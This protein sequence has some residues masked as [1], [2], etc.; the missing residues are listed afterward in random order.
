MNDI[1]RG[2]RVGIGQASLLFSITLALF[3]FVGYR[4][5]A[6]EFYSGILITQFGLIMLPAVLFLLFFRY[7]IK[8]ILRLNKIKPINIL[9]IFVIM[10]FAIPLVA[11]FNLLNLFLVK[12]I[13]GDVIINQ[14]PIAKNGSEL[15][16]NLLVI[17]GSAGIC[18]EVLFRGVLQRGYERFGVLKAIL[19][20]SFLFSLTHADFQKIF[21]TFL[22]GALIGFFVYRTNSLLSG[23]FAHFTNNAL[24]VLLTYVSNKF[25][26]AF[27]D[28]GANASSQA[29]IN[30]VFSALAEI[31]KEQLIIVFFI[32]GILFLFIAAVFVLLLYAFCKINPVKKD[33]EASEPIRLQE[34]ASGA[35]GLIWLLPGITMIAAIYLIQASNMLGLEIAFV[36]AV[37][38]LLF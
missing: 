25:L 29:D 14:I 7:D 33:V 9:I 35:K 31:P 22:L 30:S 20:T 2:K 11:V 23:M 16:L 18:E 26:S 19:L 5:Q 38:G 17:A 37:K 6:R 21:G 28:A 27:Q 15:L 36:E 3:I 24:A 34:K 32:Y 13:F 8:S 10:L 4:A 12:S 1:N